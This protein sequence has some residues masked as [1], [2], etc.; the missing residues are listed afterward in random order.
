[1]M[2]IFF[3]KDVCTAPFTRMH[4]T[5]HMSW[6]KGFLENSF[7]LGSWEY[8]ISLPY[9]FFSVLHI[10]DKQLNYIVRN[11][12]LLY[13]ILYTLLL[14]YTITTLYNY[15]YWYLPTGKRNTM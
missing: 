9:F 3:I 10:K 6:S 11:P 12:I 14:Y 2:E 5:V 13:C 1:M 4:N 15:I 7:T 8:H